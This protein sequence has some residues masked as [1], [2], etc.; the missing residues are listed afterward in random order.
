MLP[1]RFLR[2]HRI[3]QERKG[4][5]RL[6]QKL[7]RP[8]QPSSGHG[9]QF[10]RLLIRQRFCPLADIAVSGDQ[11]RLYGMFDSKDHFV[12]SLELRIVTLYLADRASADPIELKASRNREEGNPLVKRLCLIL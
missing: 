8:C 10:L 2:V 12:N 4:T 11:P 1:G 9:A 5:S 7:P 3:H 6:A